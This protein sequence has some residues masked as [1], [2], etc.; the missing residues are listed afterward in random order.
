[1]ESPIE[2][3]FIVVKCNVNHLGE[4]DRS[5]MEDHVQPIGLGFITMREFFYCN[6]RETRACEFSENLVKSS[7]GNTK[8]QMI[9]L[10]VV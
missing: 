10:S 9:S 7:E 6:L 2:N 4:S 1:M 8:S 5:E 3:N